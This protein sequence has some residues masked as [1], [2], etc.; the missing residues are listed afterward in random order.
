MQLGSEVDKPPISL[1]ILLWRWSYLAAERAQQCVLSLQEPDTGCLSEISDPGALC[2]TA[3]FWYF[4]IFISSSSL[5]EA[6]FMA[7]H[8][9]T[10]QII[11]F[12]FWILSLNF[13]LTL[14]PLVTCM[15][16]L[17]EPD[18]MWGLP[19]PSSFGECRFAIWIWLGEC[20]FS[21]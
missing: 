20:F 7:Q 15:I 4:R 3:T 18:R 6:N 21:E 13:P 1:L 10:V 2:L 14:T 16:K 19:K 5:R 17:S 12:P 11:V 8:I 9:S